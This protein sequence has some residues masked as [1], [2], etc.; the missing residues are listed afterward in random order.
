MNKKIHTYLGITN[1]I[2]IL[3]TRLIVDV[4]DYNLID[5]VTKEVSDA[6]RK[7][8]SQLEEEEIKLKHEISKL[9]VRK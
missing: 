4:L 5:S 7:K 2:F 9:K 6:D 3:S 8:I 1:M